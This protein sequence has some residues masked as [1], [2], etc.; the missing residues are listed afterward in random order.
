MIDL[1]FARSYF[2][3]V[4]P[5]ERLGQQHYTLNEFRRHVDRELDEMRML[6]M[7]DAETTATART[8]II[9]ITTTTSGTTTRK[10]YTLIVVTEYNT[11]R[12]L[13]GEKHRGFGKG[14]YNSF[15]GKVEPDETDS[16]PRS[17]IRELY[18]ETGIEVTS[19]E[20]MAQCR[21]GT[22]HFTFADDNTIE[23]V[24][25]LF[26]IRVQF[27][28]EPSQMVSTG[29]NYPIVFNLPSRSV[30]RPCEEITP[31]W[32]EDYTNIP[33]HHMFADDTIWLTYLLVTTTSP[34]SSDE[35]TI[36]LD[37]WF[38]FQPGGQET[39]TISHYYVDIPVSASTGLN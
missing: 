26:R 36:S 5:D 13:L 22:L 30:I 16:L 7:I 2:P 6:P 3:N 28:N 32:F 27:G 35:A 31:K 25:H 9:P 11:K 29:S 20:K 15:G 1:H 37:G 39:N 33:L 34:S 23:M 12:I 14:M 21:V 10:E 8:P 38:H 19:E 17:A 18:E 4:L 24:V